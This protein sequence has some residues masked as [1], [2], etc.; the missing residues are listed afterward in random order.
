MRSYILMIK[1]AASPGLQSMV[2]STPVPI[3][4]LSSTRAPWQHSVQVGNAGSRLIWH[5]RWQKPYFGCSF[6]Y[7]S[8]LNRA[9]SHVGA[10]GNLCAPKLLALKLTRNKLWTSSRRDRRFLATNC[11]VSGP[12][13]HSI[14]RNSIFVDGDRV[15]GAGIIFEVR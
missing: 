7:F 12:R 9:G 2:R 6:W 10:S 8:T 5:L 15:R 13:R 11:S 1:A 3:V 14:H 4:V